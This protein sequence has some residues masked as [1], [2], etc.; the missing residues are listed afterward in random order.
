MLA[1]RLYVEEIYWV[2]VWN[3]IFIRMFII[4][5][6]YEE[7]QCPILNCFHQYF[8]TKTEVISSCCRFLPINTSL[9]VVLSP[10]KAG[11]VIK[12]EDRCS[13]LPEGKEEKG[14]R[15]MG[16]KIKPALIK[17]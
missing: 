2:Y 5:F 6:T 15:L 11:L 1:N 13:L 3:S 7:L 8:P 14:E 9:H 17:Q 16:W 4:S 12:T 10:F